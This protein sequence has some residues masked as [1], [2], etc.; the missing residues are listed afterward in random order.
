MEDNS[1]SIALGA[2][3]I[4]KVNDNELKENAFKLFEQGLSNLKIAEELEVTYEMVVALRISYEK[5]NANLSC[6]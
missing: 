4:A 2:T 1:F 6:N 3:Q 5:R